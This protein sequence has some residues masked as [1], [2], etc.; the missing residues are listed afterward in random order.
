MQTVFLTSIGPVLIELVSSQI[1]RF[2]RHIAHKQQCTAVTL[3]GQIVLE[4]LN[5]DC[6]LSQSV[7]CMPM[8]P[9]Y[10]SGPPE[11]NRTLGSATVPGCCTG[12]TRWEEIPYTLP[13]YTWASR[14][15]FCPLMAAKPLC[16]CGFIFCLL[17][18]CE[19]R[20]TARRNWRAIGSIY[21][22]KSSASMFPC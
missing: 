19:A 2:I 20:A 5:R 12:G 6:H 13:P 8:T 9:L 11:V 10:L 16:L 3:Q 1:T 22:D 17:L 15:H 7:F 14:R 21:N 4:L 18:E